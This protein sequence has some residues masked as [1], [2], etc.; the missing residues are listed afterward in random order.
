M[1]LSWAQVANRIDE[2][3]RSDRYLTAKEVEHLDAY[4]KERIARR[5]VNFYYGK[6]AEAPCP[7]EKKD[8]VY[9][10]SAAEKEVYQQLGD[11]ERINV[12][13]GMMQTVFDSEMPGSY[14]YDHDR[15]ILT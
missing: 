10:G 1:L 3:I 2:L 14:S 5:I 13:I 8:K 9:F 15:E 11:V 7:F 6:S 12:I 4:E